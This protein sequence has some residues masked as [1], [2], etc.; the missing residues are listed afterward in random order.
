MSEKPKKEDVQSKIM[1]MEAGQYYWCACGNS[2]T[3]PF[4]DGSHKGSGEEPCAVTFEKKQEV[5]WCMC[6]KTKTPPICDKNCKE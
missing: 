3:Q 6:K 2:S 1:S 5:M 4:C